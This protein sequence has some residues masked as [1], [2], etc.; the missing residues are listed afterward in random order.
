MSGDWAFTLFLAVT[1]IGAF[2]IYCALLRALAALGGWAFRHSE[3][4]RP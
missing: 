2:G 1:F 4:Q 3:R